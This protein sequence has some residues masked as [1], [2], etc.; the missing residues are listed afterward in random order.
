MKKIIILALV[1]AFIMSCKKSGDG[2]WHCTGSDGSYKV[3]CED[4]IP[5]S[6]N[7]YNLNGTL[8]HYECERN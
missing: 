3:S 8:V 7:E 1:I 4:T 2:C 5:P 6:F